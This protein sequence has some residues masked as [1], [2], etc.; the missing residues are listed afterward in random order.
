MLTMNPS[1]KHI[2][3]LIAEDDDALRR[4]WR[5]TFENSGFQVDAVADGRHAIA[6]LRLQLPDVLVLDHNMPEADG[7]DVLEALRTL[8]PHHHVKRILV[9]ASPSFALNLDQSEVDLFLQKPTGIV[10]LMTLAE[11][12]MQARS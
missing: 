6:H 4:L 11:R 9:T 8:D 7:T 3:V 10:E 5:I 12:M 1:N 2:H